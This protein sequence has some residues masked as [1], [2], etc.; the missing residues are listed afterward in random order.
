MGHR[1]FENGHC[2][3]CHRYSHSPMCTHTSNGDPGHPE[4]NDCDH[5]WECPYCD[6][7]SKGICD[8]DGQDCD[9]ECDDHEEDG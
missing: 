6:N 9:G 7:Y 5:N 3:D 8:I 2:D 4:E 1:M